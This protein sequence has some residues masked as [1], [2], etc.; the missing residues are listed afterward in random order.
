MGCILRVLNGIFES[1]ERFTRA[2]LTKFRFKTKETDG[3]GQ[4]KGTGHGARDRRKTDGHTL[5]SRV[6]E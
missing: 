4:N 3:E 1:E 2:E 5:L 6:T